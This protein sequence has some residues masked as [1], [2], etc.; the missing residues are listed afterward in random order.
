MQLASFLICQDPPHVVP[1][2]FAACFMR[3]LLHG[4]PMKDTHAE[5]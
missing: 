2:I 1:L 4:Y 3:V 5:Y